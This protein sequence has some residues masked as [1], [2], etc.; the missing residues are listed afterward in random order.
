MS[1]LLEK[2]AAGT[3]DDP[4]ALTR[5]EDGLDPGALRGEMSRPLWQS[6][7]AETAWPSIAGW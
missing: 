3:S 7:G 6:A 4:P 1:V 5:R 2:L